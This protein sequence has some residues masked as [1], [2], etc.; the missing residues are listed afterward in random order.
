MLVDLVPDIKK[1][2][3]ASAGN[4]ILQQDG[5]KSHLQEDDEAFKA[6]VMELYGDPNAVKCILNHHSL[7]I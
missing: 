5:M 4:I 2:M 1:K 7:Q 6:K 3:H